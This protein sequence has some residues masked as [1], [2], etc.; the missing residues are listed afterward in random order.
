MVK[1]PEAQ[2]R[3]VKNIFV[4]RRCKRKVRG[5]MLKVMA[6]KVT[7]RKCASTQLRPV[8]KK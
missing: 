5:P 7:C 4:C 8:R 2:N 6:G 3:L 1:F